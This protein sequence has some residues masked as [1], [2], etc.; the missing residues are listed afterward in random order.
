[1]DSMGRG[2]KDR[3]GYRHR[4][5]S[6]YDIGESAPGTVGDSEGTWHDRATQDNTVIVDGVARN[7]EEHKRKEKKKEKRSTK[8]ASHS[9]STS[10]KNQQHNSATGNVIEVTIDRVSNAGNPIAEYKGKHVHI[11]GAKPGQTVTVEITDASSNYLTGK[12]K[13]RE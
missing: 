8:S 4:S 10:T 13:Q 9:K 12:I 11:Q 2:N 5:D 3:Y 6:G 7:Y 1:M